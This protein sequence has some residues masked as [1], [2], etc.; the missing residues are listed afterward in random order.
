LARLVSGAELDIEEHWNQ[1]E[2][3]PEK[4]RFRRNRPCPVNTAARLSLP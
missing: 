3:D 1:Y 4:K 2:N